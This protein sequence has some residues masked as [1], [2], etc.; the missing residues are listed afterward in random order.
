[1]WARTNDCHGAVISA[2]VLAFHRFY[3]GNA[4][5][6]NFRTAE[7]G[8]DTLRLYE[9]FAERYAG[10]SLRAAKNKAAELAWSHYGQFKS[11]GDEFAAYANW[12]L[13]L[14]LTPLR[15]RT[16]R[17]VKAMVVPLIRRLALG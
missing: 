8:R 6:Q 14:E 9:I 7:D 12:K 2:N 17:Q 4:T 10:F 1:M 13:W 16:A 11:S 3:T 5:W 15:Q